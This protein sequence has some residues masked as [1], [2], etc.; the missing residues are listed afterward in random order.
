ME[1]D[2]YLFLWGRRKGG[3]IFGEGKYVFV[4]EQKN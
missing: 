3:K 1:I 2:I 4:V